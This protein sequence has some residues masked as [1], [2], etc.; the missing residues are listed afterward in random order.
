MGRNPLLNLPVLVVSALLLAGG[1]SLA[2][3]AGGNRGTPGRPPTGGSDVGLPGSKQPTTRPGSH[4]SSTKDE[5]DRVAGKFPAPKEKGGSGDERRNGGTSTGTAYVD[6]VALEG[7]RQALTL[8]RDDFRVTIDGGPRRIVSLHYVFRGPQAPDA[9]RAI[10][11]G[12]GVAAHADEARTIV[13]VVDE[14]SFAAGAEPSVRS[15]VEHLLDL[16]SPVDRAAVLTLPQPGP[17]KFAGTRRDLAAALSGVVGRGSAAGTTSAA[18]L[19]AL[20]RLLTDLLKIQGPKTV[21][22]F[23]AAPSRTMRLVADTGDVRAARLSMVLDAAAASRTVIDVVEP[24]EPGAGTSELNDLAHG[25]GGTAIRLT[26][27]PDDLAPLAAVL[28]GGYILEVESQA[29]DR[30]GAS[31]ALVVTTAAKGVRLLAPTRW[32]P[33]F[34]PLPAPVVVVTP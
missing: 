22:L 18:P 4:E 16:I 23:S 15:H 11:V 27:K 12:K 29:S 32:M 28:L 25:T 31:H 7:Q 3:T 9:G 19:T 14:T 6:V 33:R 10:A 20:A 1:S 21:I 24:P 5:R 34:D 30:N 8:T 2:Q 26:G 17:L 13:I